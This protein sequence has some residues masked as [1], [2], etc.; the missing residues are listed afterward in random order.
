MNIVWRPRAVGQ[1]VEIEEYIAANN[2]TVAHRVAQRI[3]TAVAGLGRLPHMGRPGRVPGTRELV[4]AG[5][6][7]IVA[8]AVI[9]QR[10]EVLAVIHGARRWP[11]RF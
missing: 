4:I 11:R 7:Y 3:K 5:L 6:P 1:L 8:Y 10:A 2:P 9:E